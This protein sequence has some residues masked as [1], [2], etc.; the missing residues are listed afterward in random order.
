MLPKQAEELRGVIQEWFD[1]A[2]AD[3][4]VEALDERFYGHVN[5]FDFV[6]IKVYQRRIDER[7]PRYRKLFHRAEEEFGFPWTLLAAQSYQESHWNP[8]AKSPTGV[9]GM[10][11]LTQRTAKEL[12]VKNRMDPQ[13]SILGGARYLSRIIERLPE[14]IPR[15]DRLWFALAAYNIEPA[16]IW[17]ARTLAERLGKDPNA[18]IDMQTVL[19]LL[20][21]RTHFRTLKYGYARGTEPV[22]YVRRIREYHDILER[23]GNT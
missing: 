11:M 2:R 1:T 16:H 3:G 18:W 6:D 22:R 10:M 13:Q 12:D 23:H 17:D 5:K 4:S 20:S 7:L 8:K 9:R 21:Q 15:P 14:Q 19:P